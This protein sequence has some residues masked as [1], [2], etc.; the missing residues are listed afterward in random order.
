MNHH[1]ALDLARGSHEGTLTTIRGNTRPQ[2]SNVLYVLGGDDVVRISTAE[3][4]AKATNLRRTP[5]AALH[6]SGPDFWSYSVLEGDAT[7]SPPVTDVDD[8]V[9]AELRDHYRAMQGEPED[10]APFEELM[11]AERRLVVRIVVDRAYG[12]RLGESA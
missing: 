8:P 11:L 4:R 3:S 9:M 1:D 12:F 2:I 10:W 5:W 6:V 7:L